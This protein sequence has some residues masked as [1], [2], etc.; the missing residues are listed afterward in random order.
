MCVCCDVEVGLI[1]GFGLL[2]V[3]VVRFRSKIAMEN[4]AF[5]FVENSMSCVCILS[6]PI[7]SPSKQY[8]EVMEKEIECL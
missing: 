3:I 1:K 7:Y 4:G 6:C 8:I 5:A 2:F